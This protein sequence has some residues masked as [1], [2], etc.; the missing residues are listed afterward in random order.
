M[1]KAGLCELNFRFEFEGSRVVFDMVS[2]DS[3][4]AHM[5]R[6]QRNGC[7]RTL[8]VLAHG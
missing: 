1:R 6:Q 8:V 4:L 3:R 7:S 2:R 5:H